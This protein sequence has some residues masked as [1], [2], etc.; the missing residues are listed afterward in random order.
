[1]YAEV[2]TVERLSPT[3][4]RVVFGGGELASFEMVPATDA[5]I[6]ARFLPADSPVQVPFTD[7]DI[8]Q[9]DPALR[10]KPRRFTVRRW[11]PDRLELTVD[12][13]AHGDVGYAGSWAQ[14]AQAGDRLQFTGPSGSYRPGEDLD[15]HLLVG[16]E[17]ALPAIGASLEALPAGKRAVVIAV[18]DDAS[19]EIDLPTAAEVDVTWVHRTGANDITAVLPDTVAA[20]E[21][22][23]GTYDVFVKG[24]A[25]EVRAIRK[26]LLSERD[27]TDPDLV[28]ISP[29]WRRTFT[30]E[31]WRAVKKD[32]I[33]EQAND[34]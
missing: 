20:Y 12:F 30:D 17:S 19:C 13:V 24:E 32:W 31:A 11:D 22:P 18:V 23:P 10:P 25:A 7:E 2:Q 6:N 16:D 8:E 15:W 3:M 1:M 26:H 28:S 5:Y 29:Y 34:V 9:L 27:I 33:A 14:R 4:L 21:F